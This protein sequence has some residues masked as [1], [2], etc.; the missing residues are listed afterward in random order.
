[1][2]C[3]NEHS[4]HLEDGKKSFDANN[5][6]PGYTAEEFCAAITGQLYHG[7]DEMVCTICATERFPSIY[8][9]CS[10][11]HRHLAAD[12]SNIMK[13]ASKDRDYIRRNLREQVQADK[14][15]LKYA[16]ATRGLRR[17]SSSSDSST[18]LDTEAGSGDRNLGDSF[19]FTCPRVSNPFD[20]NYPTGSEVGYAAFTAALDLPFGF[21]LTIDVSDD[22]GNL[23]QPPSIDAG[24]PIRANYASRA[25]RVS[26][27]IL[28]SSMLYYIQLCGRVFSNSWCMW[29]V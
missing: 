17:S 22:S 26:D 1:M 5:P 14:A 10:N 18:A 7:G 15:A 6:P 3:L 29:I 9:K 20:T 27:Y 8:A 13:T 11:D 16:A 24:V 25:D 4:G 23:E 2:D 12:F 19:P 21:E 28:P